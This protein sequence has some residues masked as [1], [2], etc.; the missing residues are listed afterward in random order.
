MRILEGIDPAAL[1]LAD[2]VDAGEPVVLRGIASGWPLV[3][4]GLG[5]VHDAMVYLC[6]SMRVPIQYSFGGAEIGGRRSTARITG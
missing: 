2:L 4:A 5:G 6:A 1:P 3:Q